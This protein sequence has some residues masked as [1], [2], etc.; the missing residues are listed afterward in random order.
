M[1]DLQRQ[2][3]GQVR[4]PYPVDYD[5][6]NHLECDVLVIGAGAAGSCAGIAASRRGMK[7]IVCEK[8]ASKRAGNSGAGIDHW[9]DLS[10]I[11]GSS[12]T[13]EEKYSSG[14][15]GGMNKGMF[16]HKGPVQTHRDYIAEK[17]T[18][19]ALMELEKMGL[20]V[21]DEDGNFDG[22]AMQDPETRLLKSYNYA[23]MN[24]IRLRGGN[25]V[26]PVLNREL[27]KSGATVLDRTMMTGLLTEGGKSGARVCGAMGFS[28][29]T[30]EFYV[31][32]AKAVILASGYVCGNWIYSTEM[33]GN[34]YRWDPNDI[35]EGLAMAYLAG[36]KTI[37]FCSNGSTMGSH[38]FAWP[39]FGVGS[40]ANTWFPCT[41]VDNNGKQIPWIYRDGTEAQTVEE[42]INFEKDGPHM[43]FDLMG[44]VNRGEYELPFWADLSSMP[45]TERRAIWGMMVGNEGKTRYTLYDLYTR[46]GFNP[47][48]HFLMCPIDP[49]KGIGSM[50]GDG[51]AVKPWRSE[52]GG[53]GE[54]VLDWDL[55]TT[56]PGLFASGAAG[57]LEGCSLAC[58]SGFYAGNRAAEYAS[59]VAPGEVCEEQVGRERTRV[60]APAKRAEDPEACISWKEL[61]GGSSR[62]MQQCC[63]EYLSIS[64]LRIGLEWLDSIRRNEGS[65]TF[66][67]NPHELA[68]VMECETRLTVGSL[69]MNAC[70]SLLE[71]AKDHPEAFYTEE[72]MKERSRGMRRRPGAKDTVADRLKVFLCNW[73]EDGTFRSAF[74]DADNF[75]KGENRPDL[76]ENY[77]AHRAAEM[78]AGDE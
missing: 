35:G 19:D 55:M 54:L 17:G 29:E 18:W 75:L 27:K 51:D 5:K 12:R 20:P 41:I 45:E 53:Q 16:G 59:S 15:N 22:Y 77:T 73:L 7:V 43:P 76:L 21:R 42:R 37:S 24:G 33:T 60:Y 30:G 26:I 57:G 34:S 49:V 23:H 10:G 2:V 66:A 11:P 40:S 44:A 47:E 63:G 1:T 28:T 31:I 13:A 64:T 67:R 9:N 8:G 32:R 14:Y 78:E 46:S 48:K 74:A 56:V 36:A 52:R 71:A 58:S 62:V 6:V 72:E 61:W 70:I 69:F 65:M 50:H 39:R 4:W 3:S 68:R 25:F 38:P